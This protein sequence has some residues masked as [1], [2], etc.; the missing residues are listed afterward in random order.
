MKNNSNSIVFLE[1]VMI[2]VAFVDVS[3]IN[4]LLCKKYDWKS[5]IFES[6]FLCLINNSVKYIYI[7]VTLEC[8]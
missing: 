4:I 8:T 5:M 2:W 3:N 7:F 1:G 6:F